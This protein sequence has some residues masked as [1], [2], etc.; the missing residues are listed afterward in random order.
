MIA[1][2]II[3][4]AA[5]AAPMDGGQQNSEAYTSILTPWKASP[6]PYPSRSFAKE[7]TVHV[8]HRINPSLPEV[9]AGSTTAGLLTLVEKT[10]SLFDD[11][12]YSMHSTKCMFGRLAYNPDDYPDLRRAV[13]AAHTTALPTPIS[14][15]TVATATDPSQATTAAATTT[16]RTDSSTTAEPSSTTSV[17][18]RRF[19]SRFDRRAW[20]NHVHVAN[21]LRSPPTVVRARRDAPSRTSS[22]SV[23]VATVNNTRNGTSRFGPHVGINH[24]LPVAPTPPWPKHSRDT[25]SLSAAVYYEK[26]EDPDWFRRLPRRQRELSPDLTPIN[27]R[28]LL[29]ENVS[30][31]WD[32]MEMDYDKLVGEHKALGYPPLG[33]PF[34]RSITPCSVSAIERREK[35]DTEYLCECETSFDLWLEQA[36][37]SRRLLHCRQQIDMCYERFAPAQQPVFSILQNLSW[38]PTTDRDEPVLT[39]GKPVTF[40]EAFDRGPRLALETT[41]TRLYAMYV[42]AFN[43]R[44]AEYCE[45][46]AGSPMHVLLADWSSYQARFPPNLRDRYRDR[47]DF[48]GDVTNTLLQTF[49]DLPEI[50]KEAIVRA[51]KGVVRDA[52][53][54]ASDLPGHLGVVAGSGAQLVGDGFM[55]AV[56]GAAQIGSSAFWGAIGGMKSAF[57]GSIDWLSGAW[58]T[59]KGPLWMIVKWFLIII[60]I[61]LVVFIIYKGWPLWAACFKGIC[62]CVDCIT[63]LVRLCCPKEESVNAVEQPSR[64][65]DTEESELI[66][67]PGI[68]YPIKQVDDL[69]SIVPRNPP[70]YSPRVIDTE[71]LYD[72]DSV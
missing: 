61:A 40:G 53:Q 11:A 70:A 34:A 46:E 28:E 35:N 38:V 26:Q 9:A 62:C 67:V 32:V 20:R 44:D 23:R 18:R 37:W 7:L 63:Y 39:T 3:M 57:D 45:E 14:S 6:I 51:A 30:D 21:G 19:K 64:A 66:S 25:T 17:P 31:I 71:A 58:D 16:M 2:V 68:P 1:P 49:E 72:S 56:D 22:R 8:Q 33:E 43:I 12:V 10:K 5:A 27:Y 48:L 4:V 36:L 24:T 41:I 55:I 47:R 13:P 65:D 50:D 69:S 59:I 29:R 54:L 52:G 60:G 15:T 42:H